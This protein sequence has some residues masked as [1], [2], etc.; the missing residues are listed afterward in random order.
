MAHLSFSSQNSEIFEKNFESPKF[1]A[2][3]PTPEFAGFQQFRSQIEIEFCQGS[4]IA[5]DLFKSAISFVED[6]GRWE[7][8][9]ALGF[10]VHPQWQTRKPHDFGILAGF[11]NESNDFWQFKPEKPLTGND[12]KVQKYQTP[13]GNGSRAFL[14]ALPLEIRQQIEAQSHQQLSLIAES[15]DSFWVWLEGHPEI[16]LT[17]TE[18]GKKSLSLLSLAHAAIAL[19]GCDSGA[20]KDEEGT[21]HLIPDLLRFCQPGRRINLAF[22][23]DAKLKTRH[24]VE[25]AIARL[26]RLLTATGAI[27]RIVEWQPNQGKGID[28]LHANRGAAAVNE[29]IANAVPFPTW[30]KRRG[31]GFEVKPKSD[32]DRYIQKRLMRFLGYWE[33]LK[34]DFTLSHADVIYQGYAPTFEV[35]PGSI[36]LRG[37][38]GAGK[39]EATLRSLVSH[40]DKQIIWISSRNGLLYQTAERAQ[41]LGFDV[42]H[43]QDDTGNH[44]EMLT[45]GC[46]GIYTLCPDSL[47]D[48][49]VA[50]ADWSKAIIVIDE[51]S[52]VRREVLK[53]SAIM[54]EFERLLSEAST[55]IAVDAFL[56]DA[57]RR[58]IAK[59]R[60]G[61]IQ[62]IDQ[63]FEKSPMRVVWLETRNQAGDISFSHDGIPYPLLKKWVSES[64]RF[65]IPCDNK[66]QAKAVRDYLEASGYHGVLC[67]SETIA[68]NQ[69]L[70]PDPDQMLAEAQYFIYTPTAQSGLDCQ[71]PFDCGLALY[72][73]VISPI[74]FLQ[75]LGRCRQCK[76]WYVS[77]PRRS[78]DPNCPV[79]SLESNRVKGWGEKLAVTFAEL[80]AESGVKS[81]GW[82]LWQ[83]LTS[84][85]ERAFHSEYLQCL[86]QQFFESVEVAEVECDR[87]QWQGDVTRIKDQELRLI[88][89]ADLENG[90]RMLRQQK[91]PSRDA[92]VWDFALAE[93]SDKYPHV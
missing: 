61:S 72:G 26:G 36:L 13:K 58:V 57:D 59:Y 2:R 81:A 39:T 66:L 40:Q 73:G 83:S 37:W 4:A 9:Q 20:T 8:H 1:L 31:K 79:P 80:G 68:N 25:E 89:S 67:S 87:Q 45:R 74:D 93:E 88:L 69:V 35:V 15:I 92:E 62:V 91:A 86:L 70:L 11:W 32:R 56:S 18:G 17:I 64:K 29:A 27:V 47:K 71:V 5:P 30:L 33:E 41:R 52:G 6:T 75:M 19:Y 21:H 48:Y 76:E 43:Y 90:R 10:E 54:P 84:D 38:L 28:D 24:R 55:L 14:P 12:G 82:G 63:Q 53:K 46:P 34:K 77:A 85:V 22:D 65:A 7:T 49:H 16:D 78:L 42:Y 50:R 3:I 60:P 51:F 23:Q 44:R